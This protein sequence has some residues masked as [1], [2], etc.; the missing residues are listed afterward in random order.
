MTQQ[1]QRRVINSIEEI[2]DKCIRLL[3]RVQKSLGITDQRA[4]EPQSLKHHSPHRSPMKRKI[5]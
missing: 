3:S 1:P 5:T 2:N 4:T